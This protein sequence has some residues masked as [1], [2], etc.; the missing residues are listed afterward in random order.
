M[1]PYTDVNLKPGKVT[2]FSSISLIIE[3]FPFELLI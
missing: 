3:P 2:P 1:K